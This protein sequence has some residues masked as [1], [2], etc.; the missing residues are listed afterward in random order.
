MNWLPIY[1]SDTKIVKYGK[2]ALFLL[3][4]LLLVSFLVRER[5]LQHTDY[6]EDKIKRG[7][8]FL[9]AYIILSVVLLFVLM[10]TFSKA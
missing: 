4:I 3:P 7:G 2:L 5:D 9:I 6:D 1:A 8:K 10:F